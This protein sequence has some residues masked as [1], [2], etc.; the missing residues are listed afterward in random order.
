VRAEND[1]S[2]ELVGQTL[3]GTLMMKLIGL[4]A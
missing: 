4:L 1:S 3:A 2:A